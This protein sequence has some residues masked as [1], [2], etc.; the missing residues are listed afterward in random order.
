MNNI[1]EGYYNLRAKGKDKEGEMH[2]E[3]SFSPKYCVNKIDLIKWMQDYISELDESV[4]WYVEP[5]LVK[6]TST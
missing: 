5:V 2:V 3:Y 6:T 1:E 4:E